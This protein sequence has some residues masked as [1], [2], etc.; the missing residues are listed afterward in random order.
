MKTVK[1]A[2]KSRWSDAVLFEAEIDAS[3]TDEGLKIGAAVKLALVSGANLRDANLSGANLSDAYLRGANLSGANLRD[4]N[5]SGANL[6]DAYLRGAN[7]R[8]ANLR[9][10]NLRDANLSGANLSDAYLRGANLSD[11][12]LRD[13]NL[14]DANLSGANL[15]DA[16]LRGANLSDAKGIA[17]ELC[18]DLLMLLDQPGPMLRAYKL[19]DAKFKSPIQTYAKLTYKIGATLE[20]PDAD[21]DVNTH[22]GA[23]LNVA[24]LPWCLRNWSAGC[25]ILTVEF[26][27]TDIAAIPTA[28][29]GKFRVRKLTVI[30]EKTLDYEKLGLVKAAAPA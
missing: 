29:D 13:A 6:S 5:L 21:T 2:I 30:G 27:V 8:G 10:A 23:G 3:I 19:V 17:P 25:K 9:D 24:T 22:C 12:N 15:S 4:A 18:T 28:T 11:A 14:R 20:E 16:Y 1:F 7:L 26:A